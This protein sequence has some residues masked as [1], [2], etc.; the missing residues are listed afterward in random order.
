H[1]TQT[2]HPLRR[3][4]PA[5]PGFRGAGDV[6][7]PPRP[8][9]RSEDSAAPGALF[10]P[11]IKGSREDARGFASCVWNPGG[12]T[13]I[14]P[15]VESSEPGARGAL[16]VTVAAEPGARGGNPGCSTMWTLGEVTSP[17][18]SA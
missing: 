7:R 15:R 2:E 6:Q 14:K 10:G 3:G 11:P 17:A 9:F 13:R 12:V 8:G 18:V 1:A 5:R 4:R 16:D